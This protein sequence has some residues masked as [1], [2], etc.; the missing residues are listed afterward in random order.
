MEWLGAV[1]EH[2][3]VDRLKRR[4]LVFPSNVDKKSYEGELAV[5]LCNYTDVY[6]RDEILNDIDFML[7]S[8]TT[9]Q[10]GRFTLRAGD[11][12]ITK[13]SETAD[14]IAIAAYVPNDLPGVVCGYHLAMVRPIHDVNGRFVK[15]LFDAHYAKSCFAVRANGLTRKGL[16]QH[17]I[18]NVD[19]PWPP[20]PEQT[21]I[22]AFLDHETAKIDALIAEQEKL[23]ELLK[24]KRQA[25]ISHAVT[26]GLNPDAPMK[27]SGI[28]WLGEVPAHWEVCQLRHCA[29]LRC[30]FAFKSEVFRDSG[31]SVIRMNN[32]KRG[33]LDLSDVTRIGVEEQRADAALGSGDLLWGMS[34]SIGPTGS[35]GN[36]AVVSPEDLPAQLNQR[37][38]KFE[39]Q[40]E[41]LNVSYL[42][43]VIQTSEFGEQILMYV[44]GTAQFNVS[45]NQVESCYVQLPT[46][47]EQAAI[48]EFLER[49]MA[50]MDDLTIQSERAIELLRER[51]SA[52]ISAAV[53]GQIDVRNFSGSAA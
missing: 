9:E 39:V 29:K 53:T 28:E 3:V 50:V 21:A 7:A 26:K 5:R 22:A 23:I 12:I 19:L 37:V 17:E 48:V 51:R 34:G 30:G 40:P 42:R 14:D 52:L 25:V 4:C 15:C 47:A 49:E 8:A 1:P 44:A 27:D 18:Q 46:Q 31:V 41:M 11:T 20:L 36:F 10:V 33:V 32:L 35:L 16:G 43:Y 6:Y 38:G 13:D 2:W 45:S 24:E